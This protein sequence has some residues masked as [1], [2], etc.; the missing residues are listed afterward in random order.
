[1][2]APIRISPVRFMGSFNYLSDENLPTDLDELRLVIRT[3]DKQ[4]RHGRAIVSALMSDKAKTDGTRDRVD[5]H[6]KGANL[7]DMFQLQA[8]P[9]D[10]A[11]GMASEVLIE[12]PFPRAV[13]RQRREVSS[14]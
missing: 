5:E 4:V 8:F 6:F 14:V 2:S 7:E 3:L 12:D 9:S 11:L 13:K 10:T 1:M